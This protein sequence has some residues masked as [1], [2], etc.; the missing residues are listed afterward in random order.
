M[1]RIV[2]SDMTLPAF[3]WRCCSHNQEVENF[4]AVVNL[5]SKELFVSSLNKPD[6]RSELHIDGI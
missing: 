2:P 5:A 4:S 6:E 3:C 1:S